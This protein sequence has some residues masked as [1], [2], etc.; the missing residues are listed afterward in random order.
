MIKF[1]ACKHK[2]RAN[3]THTHTPALTLIPKR[4]ENFL[5]FTYFMKLKMKLQKKKKKK[6]NTKANEKIAI[7]IQT[8]KDILFK[9][10]N[11]YPGNL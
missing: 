2:L 3:H 8:R 5:C 10:H 7:Y 6:R 1:S 9:E 11:R 4:T